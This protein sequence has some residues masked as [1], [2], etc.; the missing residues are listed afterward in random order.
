M[1]FSNYLEENTMLCPYQ[2]GFRKGRST[3]HAITYLLDNIR[4][5][6]D[7]SLITGVLYMDLRKAFDTVHHAVLLDKLKSYGIEKK[8][9]EWFSDY[10]FNRKQCVLFDGI[11]SE[12]NHV[13]CGVPQGPY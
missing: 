1:Q 5:N 11:C 7:K 12:S 9:Y 10:L 6:I 4:Q 3:Q 8:E 13:V 2:N